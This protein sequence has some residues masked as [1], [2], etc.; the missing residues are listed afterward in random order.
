[1]QSET[2]LRTVRFTQWLF[3]FNACIWLV[4]AVNSIFR[5]VNSSNTPLIAIWVVTILM[6]GNAGT[7]L[8]TGLWLGQRSRW[9]FFLA[10]VVL[11][12]NILLTFTDQVGFYDIVTVLLDFVILGLLLYDRKNYF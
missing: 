9:A 4:F 1:M 3:F 10:L 7:M 2:R 11:F 8:V 12:V 6:F 5:L